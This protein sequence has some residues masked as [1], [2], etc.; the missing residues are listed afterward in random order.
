MRAIASAGSP[1]T[2]A[3]ATKLLCTAAASSAAGGP[4]PATSPSAKPN[5]R[6]ADLEVVE[7][8]AADRAARHRRRPRDR[9]TAVSN[10]APG[11]SARWIS[12]AMRRSRS[13]R[14]FSADSAYSRAL[15][16][17]SAACVANASSERSVGCDSI[18]LRS[19][20]SRYSTP[21][22]RWPIVRSAERRHRRDA[23]AARTGRGGCRRRSS[24]RACR[25]G[26][27]PSGRRRCGSRRSGTPR[28]ESSR[29]W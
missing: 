5:P 29:W 9:R 20:P 16:M 25:P 10:A 14:A 28:A 17:A 19:R 26:C 1:L 21:I 2:G 15:S 12:A 23:A 11:S 13:M 8:V 3:C 7:E 24:H 27:L 18:V 6:L 22:T 4:L